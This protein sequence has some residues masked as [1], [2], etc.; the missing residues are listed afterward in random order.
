MLS[1]YCLQLSG[2]MLQNKRFTQM[3]QEKEMQNVMSANLEYVKFGLHVQRATRS[4]TR[5]TSGW[6]D[7]LEKM[8]F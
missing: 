6:R 2:N 3:K 8:V 5:Y 1:I 7:S 4:G